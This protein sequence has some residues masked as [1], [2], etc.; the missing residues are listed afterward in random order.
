MVEKMVGIC[1]RIFAKAKSARKD[2]Y[3]GIL[4]YR[5]TPKKLGF[6]PRELLMSRKLRSVLPVTLDQLLPK[7]PPTEQIK[8]NIQCAKQQQ[9]NI[10]IK[11]HE[12]RQKSNNM[13]KLGNQLS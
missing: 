6:S 3:L 7:P 4:E 9:K 5:T 1:K 12:T 10:M 2:P 8:E 13:T 11:V